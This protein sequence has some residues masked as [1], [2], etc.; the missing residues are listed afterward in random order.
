M[1]LSNPDW[2]ICKFAHNRKAI[3]LLLG[4][5]GFPQ[6]QPFMVRVAVTKSVVKHVMSA[7][8]NLPIF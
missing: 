7:T 5:L 4:T 2:N 3:Q 8:Q 1:H 6:L